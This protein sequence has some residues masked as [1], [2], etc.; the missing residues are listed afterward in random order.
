MDALG[1]SLPHA[2]ELIAT[3]P[4]VPDQARIDDEGRD[5]C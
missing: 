2:G 5:A 4:K 3:Y 1:A